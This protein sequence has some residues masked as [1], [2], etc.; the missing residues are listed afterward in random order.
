MIKTQQILHYVKK[1]ITTISP[2][3][4]FCL[5]SASFL[6]II[7]VKMFLIKTEW[8][9]IR[10]EVIRKNWTENYD[11]YGYR[12][13][14]WLTDKLKV[15]Q[16]ER[17][18]SG[19]TTAK[20]QTIDS[21]LRG[22][23]ESEIYLTVQVEATYN[24]RTHGYVYNSRQINVGAQVEFNFDNN[25][26]AGQIIDNNYPPKGYPT[27]T[28]TVTARA[29]N[30]YKSSNCQKYFRLFGAAYQYQPPS[31]QRPNNN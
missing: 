20:I 4:L 1:R 9:T 31:C 13:P 8:H 7:V 5:I 22:G 23:E 26:V 25:L 24:Y 19:R 17:N 18:M 30:L 6:F 21:Y 28:I 14:F 16:V 29:K 15:G 27:K 10:V 11:P 12:A 3:E 2:I